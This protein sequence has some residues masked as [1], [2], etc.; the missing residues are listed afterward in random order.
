ME[1]RM[2]Y[3]NVT[4]GQ[5][6]ATF[7]KLGGPEAATAI[8]RG[9]KIVVDKSEY[10]ELIR[11]P[12][13]IKVDYG[14]SIEEMLEPL[15]EKFKMDAPHL[16]RR[17]PRKRKPGV[18]AH[19]NVYVRRVITTVSREHAAEFAS[20]QGKELADLYDFLS[21]AAKCPMLETYLE[22][23]CPAEVTLYRGEELIPYIYFA[24][25]DER[26]MGV[27]KTYALGA[28]LLRDKDFV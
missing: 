25:D 14:L 2:K 21:F 18:V 8:R 27:S 22:I 19:R 5:I 9:D 3:S 26:Y 15:K 6:E 7:N 16:A 10:E 28:I 20:K 17:F 13:L 12:T 1:M 11:P 23:T 24:R 4:L